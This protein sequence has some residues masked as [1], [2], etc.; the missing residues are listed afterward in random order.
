MALGAMAWIVALG[1]ASRLQTRYWRDD[2]VMWEHTLAVDGEDNLVARR[3]LA[4]WHFDNDHDLERCIM[5]FDAVFGR[6]PELLE[7]SLDWYMMALCESGR[8]DKA[9]ELMVYCVARNDE[10]IRR[11]Q[12]KALARG[13][14]LGA[15]KCE[16]LVYA[17]TAWFLSQPGMIKAS[18]EELEPLARLHP[19]AKQV[20][21]LKRKIE[22]AKYKMGSIA[23]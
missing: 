20:R 8:R 5:H 21:Y 6:R 17:R 15:D 13:E 23:I 9:D 4:L 2:R 16:W 3:G 1:Y 11:E 22:S 7:Q 19:D 10:V 18:E 12:T 14:V